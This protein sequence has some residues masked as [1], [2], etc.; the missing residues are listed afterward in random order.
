[1]IL[2]GRVFFIF[3]KKYIISLECSVVH[4][5][6]HVG[7]MVLSLKKEGCLNF[8]TSILV[9]RETLLVY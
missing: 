5:N 8:L 4:I 2:F 3:Y 9:R 1:M 6:S 7:L